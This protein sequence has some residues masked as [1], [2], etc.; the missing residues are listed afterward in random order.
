MKTILLVFITCV[1]V[2]IAIGKYHH[3]E[4]TTTVIHDTWKNEVA[5]TRIRETPLVVATTSVPAT[6][7]FVGDIMLARAVESR[8]KE[9]GMNYPFEGLQST[10]ASPDVTIG[11]FEGV[12]TKVHY[13]TPNF[14]FQFSV[15]PL[16]LAHLKTVGFDV[17]S[18]AN[19][20]TLDFGTSSLSYTHTLC[21]VYGLVCMGSP[22]GVSS[23]STHVVETNKY[24]IGIVFVHTLYAQSN[25]KSLEA[26]LELL[27]GVSD[28]QVAYIHWGEEYMLT[29]NTSQEVLAKTLIDEGVDAVIGHHPHVVQDVELYNGKPIFY[30]LGN[31]IFDQFFSSDVQEMLGVHMKIDDSEIV[32]TLMPFSSFD[33]HSQP[34]HANDET[35]TALRERVLSTLKVDS[36]VN[37]ASGTI[38]V[39]R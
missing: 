36:R 3:V 28:I 30:S 37:V 7:L 23:M 21:G 1:V 5:Y 12:V 24:R 31:F 38:T 10:L 20:H 18:F 27:R 17:L 29:H 22:T 35:A 8:M 16:Y 9:L 15:E 13:P 6:L 34:H 11:N 39:L 19:N 4:V 14:T 25:V 2:C 32:Y 33:T 26:A